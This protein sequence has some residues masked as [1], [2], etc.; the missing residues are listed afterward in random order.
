MLTRTNLHLL[1]FYNTFYTHHSL[2]R[3][4]A[5]ALGMGSPEPPPP[6][7]LFAHHKRL[8]KP[9][10][11]E[12][13]MYPAVTEGTTERFWLMNRTAIYGGTGGTGQR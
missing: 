9:S 11:Q 12:T 6:P 10:W 13:C 3:S 7:P 4:E 5:E 1:L 8:P 2:Q